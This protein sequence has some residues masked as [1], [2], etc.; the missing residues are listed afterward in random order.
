M[1]AIGDSNST[2]TI[3]LGLMN[4]TTVSNNGK[5]IC[6]VNFNGS[7]E[8]LEKYNHIL[9]DYVN[10]AVERVEEEFFIRYF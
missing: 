6:K 5:T 2:Q 8:E 9:I 1:S 3:E 10:S 7:D 4:L